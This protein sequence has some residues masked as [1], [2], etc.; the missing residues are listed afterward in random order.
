[1]RTPIADTVRC[2]RM[3]SSGDPALRLHHHGGQSH[4]ERITFRK[5]AHFLARPLLDTPRYRRR[6]RWNLNTGAGTMQI[7]AV[8]VATLVTLAFVTPAL[9][10]V[11]GFS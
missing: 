6:D 7:A 3:T 8:L 10:T 5:Q 9:A 2:W 11:W 1:M 4:V